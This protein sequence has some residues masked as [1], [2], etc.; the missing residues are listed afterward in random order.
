MLQS[1]VASFETDPSALLRAICPLP[2]AA[3]LRHKAVVAL[4]S[5]V[6]VRC[7]AHTCPA[8]MACLRLPA[9]VQALSLPMSQISLLDLQACGALYGMLLTDAAVVALSQT[10]THPMHPHDMLLVANF[11][12]ASDGFRQA[13]SFMPVCLPRFNNGAF[14]HALVT[15]LHQVRPRT[16]CR[17]TLSAWLVAS[18]CRGHVSIRQH[19]VCHAGPLLLPGCNVGP[20][21]HA[22][23]TYRH[24]LR[25]GVWCFNMV[26]APLQCGGLTC[27]DDGIE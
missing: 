27:A 24:Q 25:H 21:L 12:R 10:K 26:P 16:L 19:L 5:A 4:H 9:A 3:S 14:L 11:V 6:K 20:L 8:C 17:I 1:L 7:V 2:L 23:V 22:L 13:Q 15:Y 18:T